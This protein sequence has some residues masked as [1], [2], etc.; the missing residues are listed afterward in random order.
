MKGTFFKKST[1]KYYLRLF[2]KEF[3]FKVILIKKYLLNLVYCKKQT[4]NYNL[5]ISFSIVKIN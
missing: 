5:I 1:V 2:N 3:L 4:N